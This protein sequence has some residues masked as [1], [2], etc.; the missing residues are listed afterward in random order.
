MSLKK[1]G[2]AAG[3]VLALACVSWF[4]RPDR[5]NLQAAPAERIALLIRFGV[6]GRA[7]VDWSGSIEP[8]PQR[9]ESWQFD[10]RDG[11]EGN[12]WRSTTRQETYWDAPYESSMQPTSRRDKVTTKGVMVELDRAAAGR[13]EIKT[14]QGNFSITL[15]EIRW[16]EPRRFL[17]DRCEVSLVPAAQPLAGGPEAEDYPA[18]LE[19]RDGTLWLVY[20]SFDQDGD[21]IFARRWSAG[22]WSA[23]EAVT[24]EKGDYFRASIAQD[25]RGR[26]WI[27]WSAQVNAN[28]DLYARAWDG[29]S[30]SAVER[31]TEAPGPDIYHTLTG[32]RAGNLYLAW[33]SARSG[34]FDIF[35]E[36]HDGRGW[37][38]EIQVSSDSAN[39]WEPALASAPD[40]SVTVLWD[41]Y[42]RGNYDIVARTWRS[43]SL[44]PLTGIAESGAFEARA[45]AQ[46]D[47]RGRLWIA[48][49]EG[50]WNWGKDYGAGV[51]ENGRGLM[52]RRH[53][54]VAVLAAGKQLQPAA[55]LE[56]ALPADLRHAFLQPR[57]ILDAGDNPWVLFR[58][59]VNMPVGG[60]ARAHW[61][62]GA[63]S[64]QGGRWLPAIEF[65]QGFGRIDTPSA[66]VLA[67]DGRVHIAW[68]TDG[69]PWPLVDRVEHNLLHA[70]VSSAGPAGEP[71]LTAFAPSSENLPASHASEAEDVARIRAW[72]ARIDGRE[73]RIVRGDIHRHTDISWD[74]NR[75]GSLHDSYRYALDA[76]AMDYLGVCDHQAG[77]MIPYNWWMIQKAADLFTIPGRFAPLYSY[78]R[79]LPWPNGHRNVL[80]AER[81]RPVLAISQDEQ[82]GQEGAAKLYEY[83]R[84]F[85]GITASHTTATGA[86]TDWR[87]SSGEVEPVV[88]IYQGFRRNY[89]GPGTPRAPEAGQEGRFAAGFVWNAWAKGIKLGVQSSSDHVST[90]ISY[91]AFYVDRIDRRAVLEAARA[92]RS[93][94]A[95]DNLILDFRAGDRLMGAEL[96][97][98]R[99]LPL[100][101]YVRGTGPIA[102]VELI[103][104]N[105]I[106]Y[107]APGSG[108][109]VKFTYTDQET[110]P[111][112]SYYY[113]RAEQQD[114]QL[115]WSSPI[116]IHYN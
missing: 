67:R 40:G 69:R 104:N 111:G 100:E 116:W 79:S 49:E 76:A 20:Q 54:R 77:D 34:Q 86:G 88:E 39:D 106:V 90:H 42:G 50:D 6:D 43:G 55:T 59:R 81:G 114:G 29:K 109:E 57:M 35:L 108:P 5:L 52:V 45:S 68:P 46:Y 10:A 58:Y 73:F 75:D 93:F 26:I 47:R 87:D 24:P 96:R 61:R 64:F 15:N 51:K 101:A 89:E 115:A 99:P 110:T 63:T 74:G 78:E 98:P 97:S 8:A 48:F 2:S 32:D 21:R 27:V 17:E 41:T 72:R 62:A 53:T 60:R 12:R 94:A 38:R 1:L 84:R 91:A 71:A 13:V 11:I 18:L 44:G 65:P 113:I 22:A 19:A 16:G 23:P 25:Q 107:T 102:R 36:R 105:R 82:R 28:W 56:N 31:L 3:V 4:T 83:L 85:G 14:A 66:A 7:D 112:E 92:R 30:W 80:F 103:K 37:S 9:L 95:T 70:T 33:M